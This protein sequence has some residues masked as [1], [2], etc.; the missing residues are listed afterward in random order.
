MRIGRGLEE[1]WRRYEVIFSLNLIDF[2]RFFFAFETSIGSMV[3]S[4]D[5]CWGGLRPPDPPPGGLR[6]PGPP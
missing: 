1:D 6:P 5:S 2:R 4:V 3:F